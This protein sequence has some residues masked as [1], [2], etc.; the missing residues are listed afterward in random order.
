MARPII[1]C[2]RAS[3]IEAF[4]QREAEAF[5]PGAIVPISRSRARAWAA[6]PHAKADD[7]VLIVARLEGRCVGYLGLLPG[8]LRVHDRVEP[9]S[10]LSTFFVPESLRDQAIGGLLLMRAMALGRT[11]A[12]SDSSEDAARTFTAVGFAPPQELS[13]FA[14]DMQRKQNWLALPLRA[15]RRALLERNRPIPEV[16]E[17]AINRSARATAYLL[18]RGLGALAQRR[19]GRWQVRALEHLPQTKCNNGGNVHFVRDRALLEWL[20]ND[21]WVT[22][23]RAMSSAAYYFDDFREAAYHRVFEL[24]KQA[25][26]AAAGWAI[27]YFDARRERRRVQV[28]DYDLKAATDGAPLLIAALSAAAQCGATQV[29]VPAVCASALRRL[30]PLGQL[31]REEKRLSYYRPHANSAARAALNDIHLTYADGDLGFA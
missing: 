9:V 25:S 12:A 4:A 29:F 27:L 18:L 31:F 13:Y 5:G 26:P 20:L 1:E 22:T 23:D 15:L 28:L 14:L 3:E 7:V 21:P 6:N 10:W 16:I 17:G 30:G 24:R 19:L 8:R 11:L 2:V